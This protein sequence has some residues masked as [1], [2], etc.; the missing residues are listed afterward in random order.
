MA[1]R[2]LVPARPVVWDFSRSRLRRRASSSASSRSTANGPDLG[3]REVPGRSCGPSAQAGPLEFA[4]RLLGTPT[5]DGVIEG[6]QARHAYD[7]AFL[8]GRQH[9]GGTLYLARPCAPPSRHGAG[10]WA[11]PRRPRSTPPVRLPAASVSTAISGA[12]GNGLLRAGA[13]PR[14]RRWRPRSAANTVGDTVAWHTPAVGPDGTVI[15]PVR[16]TGC[17]PTSSWASGSPT[18]WALGY[19]LPRDSR[20]RRPPLRHSG[21]TSAE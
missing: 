17:L 12:S 16:A 21:T 15:L 1:F 18:W 14:S 7:I 13:S 10:G 11:T 19:V 20:A 5:Q 3:G 6:E 4:W 9:H 2:T 8:S